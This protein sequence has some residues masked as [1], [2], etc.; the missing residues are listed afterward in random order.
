MLKYYKIES[1]T[2]KF[3]K[4]VLNNKIIIFKILKKFSIF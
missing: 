3:F 1:I 2:K 4:I